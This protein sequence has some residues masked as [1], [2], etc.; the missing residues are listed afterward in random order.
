MKKHIR[1]ASFILCALLLF[2]GCSRT[3]ADEPSL[4]DHGL[5]VIGLLSEMASNDTWVDILTANK[6]IRERITQAAASD[7]TQPAAVY[8]LSFPM[9]DASA[10]ANIPDFSS[11][12][13]SLRTALSHR[14]YSVLVNQINAAAGAEV[15]AAATVCTAS[16]AFQSRECTTDMLYLYTFESGCPI[17]VVFTPGEDSTVTATATLLLNQ[18]FPSRSPEDLHK[19]FSSDALKVTAVSP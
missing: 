14:L 16:K 15:L 2:T 13:E 17:A 6:S 18:D 11:L 5:D 4:Y 7:Y 3:Q 10:L 9:E 19:Y 8:Q 12:P 1:L